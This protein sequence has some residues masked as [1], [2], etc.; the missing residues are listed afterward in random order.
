MTQTK[1]S[2]GSG[3]YFVK[4]DGILI[5]HGNESITLILN[6]K[7]IGFPHHSSDAPLS[8]DSPEAIETARKQC[9]EQIDILDQKMREFE[10]ASGQ[11]RFAY[12][13]LSERKRQNSK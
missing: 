4:T 10:E 2:G 3:V 6:G 7:G 8:F 5:E 11:L 12:Q 1:H 13:L 9:I